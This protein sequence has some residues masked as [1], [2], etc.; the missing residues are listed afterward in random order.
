MIP[1]EFPTDFSTYAQ[2]AGILTLGCLLLTVVAFILKWGFRFRLVGATSFMGVL[3]LGLFALGLGLFTH[4]VIP[5]AVRYTLVYDNGANQA[6]IVVPT[7]ISE[8][9]VEA[10]LRQAAYDL[11][12]AGRLGLGDDRLIVRARTVLHP[13]AGVSKPLYLGQVKRSLASREDDQM[14]V[15]VFSENL[16]QLLKKE[17]QELGG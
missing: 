13:E 17:S 12:S 7:P 4:T 1:M 11:Y 6:V 8:S 16:A 15:Q 10:T 5:G 9:E 2:W 14:Q 3:T